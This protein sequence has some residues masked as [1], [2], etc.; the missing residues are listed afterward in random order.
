MYTGS[1]YAQTAQI[2]F[3]K[4][5]KVNHKTLV[6]GPSAKELLLENVLIYGMCLIP[7]F[8]RREQT[9]TRW[10]HDDSQPQ[11][12]VDMATF[13]RAGQ[14]DNHGLLAIQWIKPL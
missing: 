7:S 11:E 13:S 1:M 10:R 12:R 8:P 9:M 3:T 4:S 2:V 6:D 5:S 14:C